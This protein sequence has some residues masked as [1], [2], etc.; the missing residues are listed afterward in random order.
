MTVLEVMNDIREI[1][2]ILEDLNSGSLV[3]TGYT[4]DYGEKRADV[5]ETILFKYIDLLESLKIKE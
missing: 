2:D 5:L 1:K 3:F 4:G